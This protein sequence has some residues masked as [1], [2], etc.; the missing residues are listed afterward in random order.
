M[1]QLQKDNKMIL[2]KIQVHYS[3]LLSLG[4]FK[5]PSTLPTIYVPVFAGTVYSCQGYNAKETQGCIQGGYWVQWVSSPWVLPI[6]VC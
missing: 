2:Q 5:L 4:C 1:D 6:M 3:L